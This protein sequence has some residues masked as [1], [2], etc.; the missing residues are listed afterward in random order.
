MKRIV[1]IVIL[2]ILS[3]LAL[4]AQKLYKPNT[5]Y[6]VLQP[7]DYGIGIRYD[8]MFNPFWGSYIA[9]SHGNYKLET[10]EIIK[11]HY[12]V[13][14]GVLLYLRPSHRFY[15]TYLG[16][17]LSYN[18]YS[19]LYNIPP[20]APNSMLDQWSFEL[21]CHARL[22][23]KFNIGVRVDPIKW[24]SSIDFGISF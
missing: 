9:L 11:N 14:S 4:S 13:V 15:Q 18:E 10:G 5:I 19:G 20:T 17:G 3:S 7:V 16:V 22:A 12:K 23:R 8:R 6:L 1:A 24:D 2:L 21:S